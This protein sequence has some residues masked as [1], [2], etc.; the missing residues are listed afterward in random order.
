M[1]VAHTIYLFWT[2]LIYRKA[3][4]CIK[5]RSYK[6]PCFP[7]FANGE[8]KAREDGRAPAL[9][10]WK[11]PYLAKEEKLARLIIKQKLK[12][13]LKSSKQLQV[14]PYLHMHV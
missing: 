10:T 2:V 11:N 12:P 14:N 1:H 3:L 5:D 13:N 6:E 4:N 8:N 7:E 9:S